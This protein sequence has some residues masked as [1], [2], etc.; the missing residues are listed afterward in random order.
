MEDVI[1]EDWSD[2]DIYKFEPN[3]DNE[4]DWNSCPDVL[5]EIANY[6]F[7]SKYARYLPK[8][9]RRET[10]E[11]AVDRVQNMNLKKFKGDKLT[12]AQR[13]KVRWAFGFVRERKVLPSMRVMQ[14]GGI[15]VEAHNE[16]AFNCSVRHIDSI[17][18]FA[19][20]FFLL[21]CG[22]GV[23]LGLTKKHVN[24]IPAL[25]GPNDRTGA[26]LTYVID[27][28]IEGWADS[29]EALLLCYTKNNPFSGRKIAF[30]YSKIRV[31]GS[32]LKVGGGKAPGYEPLKAAHF[33]IKKLLELCI[34]GRNQQQL[35]PIDAYDIMMHTSD[36]VLSGGVRRSATIVIFDK[37]DEDMLE[38][39][40]GNWFE[41]NPQRARSN[42]SVLLLRN[43][44]S[45]EEFQ[46]IMQ[47]TLQQGEPGFLFADHEDTL[48][49]PCAEILFIPVT[50]EGRTGVQFCNLS[51]IN[52]SLVNNEQDYLEAAEA[53][54]IIGTL[55]A[56]YT[57]F[58]YLSSA[59]KELTEEEAL[60]GVSMTA[61]M[62]TPTI[63]LDPVMQHKAAKKA[64]ETN[65]QW[66]EI[67][68]V[69]QAARVTCVK[70][71]GSG[72]LAV[73]TMASGMHAAE[74]HWMFRRVQ[75]NKIDPVYLHLKE[76]NPHLCEESVW[77][78][79]NT[80]DVI[81]FPVR[82]PDSAMVKKDLNAL[83]HLDMIKSTQQNW[84]LP[85]TTQA[86]NKPVTHSVSCTVRVE[87]HEWEQVTNYLY[88]NRSFFAA[89]SLLPANG[90]KIYAQAPVESVRTEEE[91]QQFK[92]LLKSMQHV[93]YTTLVETEDATELQ[94]ELACGGKDGC[95]IR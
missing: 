3:W 56:S 48:T 70:P 19:E 58:P 89:V 76:Q 75:A 72:S 27:D 55:Q 82:V 85:G 73:G 88:M 86:N 10:W 67:L 23:G 2:E 54:S 77:S 69:N 42:N 9:Q 62:E 44:L 1:I 7:V 61:I 81:T 64:V 78:A 66:A 25:V 65:K 43:D 38:A 5:Q 41:K 83:E 36:A 26:V 18:A 22:C 32:P 45:F 14:Y 17:R 53:A 12:P 20:V 33:K 30:D 68:G 16:R 90:D 49:N 29:V 47:R 51:S 91:F 60:L 28:T 80:D 11:E 21:L 8:L 59:A 94:Q 95:E 79:N 57:D 6:I 31:K 40:T 34:E 74:D 4:I 84:V 52:G 50:K 35:R 15:A 46:T 37:D 87:D 93:D 92:E 39:K 13:A 24:H 63:L 71:E